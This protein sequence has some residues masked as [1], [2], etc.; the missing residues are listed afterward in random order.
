MRVPWYARLHT[1]IRTKPFIGPA[2]KGLKWFRV[3]GIVILSLASA[4]PVFAGQGEE[5]GTGVFRIQSAVIPNE[6][7]WSV[8]Y[9]G[10]LQNIPDG[11]GPFNSLLRNSEILDTAEE[12]GT[13]AHARLLALTHTFTAAYSPNERLEARLAVPFYSQRLEYGERYYTH[14]PFSVGDAR[15]GLKHLLPP[16]K[17]PALPFTS[18][19]LLGVSLPTSRGETPVPTRFEHVPSNP[20]VALERSH[21][22]GTRRFGWHLGV[23][24]T[25]DL[26]ESRFRWPA[27]VHANLGYRKNSPLYSFVDDFYDVFSLGAGFEKSLASRVWLKGEYWH[28]NPVGGTE[29]PGI[30][31]LDDISLGVEYETGI[32]LKILAGAAV[33]LANQESSYV[34][35]VDVNEYHTYNMNVRSSSD[36]QVILAVT[37]SGRIRDRDRDGD[38]VPD[39]ID[40]CPDEP[41]GPNGKYGC[42]IRDRDLDGVPDDID[43]CPDIPQGPL[44]VD[45]CPPADTDLD[46]VCDPWVALAN[47]GEQFADQ[48]TGSDLCPIVPG[49]IAESG[50]PAP[51]PMPVQQKT[52]V[53]KGVNFETGKSTLLPA[54]FPVL[55]EIAAQL[56]ELPDIEIEVSGH[57]D[58]QG[59]A[60]LNLKL[61]QAR[62]QTV[63]EYLVSQ[64]VAAGRLTAK[65]YGQEKPIEPNTTP[66]GRAQ[67]RRVELNRL[68]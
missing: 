16:L 9:Y 63:M 31:S 7:T 40:R 66:A 47:L 2:A 39:K 38:G 5:G 24:A 4:F 28:E 35:F 11:I 43:Q 42:P 32:G 64:G 68:K 49:V 22:D 65:G 33:G 34:P 20:D 58:N 67:N 46:G 25:A 23:A 51:V 53:L 37:Y 12:P 18:A 17:L 29:R 55:D 56:R 15:V 61:S 1:V 6:K 30:H 27:V 8:G 26:A 13:T 60:A 21:A 50:C 10:R 48:C 59:G 44:G 45:G 52:L 62:A 54:S 57:T 19:L 41:Q 3:A 36:V 14:S